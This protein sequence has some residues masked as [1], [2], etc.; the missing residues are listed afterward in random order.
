MT[1]TEP[2][3]ADVRQEAEKRRRRVGLFLVGLMAVAAI[4]IFWQVVFPPPAI[5]PSAIPPPAIPPSAIPPPAIPPS[6]T[7]STGAVDTATAVPGS[8]SVFLVGY[9]AS[10]R[11]SVWS[12]PGW[13]ARWDVVF[14]NVADGYVSVVVRLAEVPKEVKRF[15]FYV[16]ETRFG[17][18]GVNYTEWRS[19]FRPRACVPGKLEF[20][21]DARAT[22][23]TAYV[24]KM[25]VLS[26]PSS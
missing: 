26:Y 21:I 20:V 16:N 18:D 3:P 6:E 23:E 7:P 2:K 12:P 22:G 8:G 24:V 10:Q 13:S 1:H 14:C 5:P 15:L 17:W 11:L 25:D 4:L 19:L 9:N